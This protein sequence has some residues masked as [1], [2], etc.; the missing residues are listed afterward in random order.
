MRTLKALAI[1]LV[2]S[3]ALLAAEGS[4]SGTWKFNPAKSKVPPGIK[5]QTAVIDADDNESSS[6]TRSLPMT[7]SPLKL[8]MKPL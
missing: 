3:L 8:V 6:T 7:A 5:S 4:F 2:T 1:V